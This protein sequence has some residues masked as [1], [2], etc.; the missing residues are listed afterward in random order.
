L[1][2]G[3][4]LEDAS[5]LDVVLPP[6]L[7]RVFGRNGECYAGQISAQG[8]A[9]VTLVAGALAIDLPARSVVRVERASNAPVE[10]GLSLRLRP[11]ARDE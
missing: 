1:P 7:D 11:E 3:L 4:A 8:A 10:V 5:A 6:P 2:Q 9:G